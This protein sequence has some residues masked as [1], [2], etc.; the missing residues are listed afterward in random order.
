MFSLSQV[1]QNLGRSRTG[2]WHFALPRPIPKGLS[3]E[4]LSPSLLLYAMNSNRP[5]VITAAIFSLYAFGPRSSGV[6]AQEQAV[7]RGAI[8]GTPGAGAPS[9]SV[10]ATG[11]EWVRVIEPARI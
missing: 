2:S 3:D 11:W 8:T 4:R 7:C 10:R 1:Y 6:W 9:F 5:W